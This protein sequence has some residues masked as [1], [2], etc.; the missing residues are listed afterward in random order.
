M[1]KIAYQKRQEK[2]FEVGTW[3][4][5]SC[6]HPVFHISRL[7]EFKGTLPKE[8]VDILEEPLPFVQSTSTITTQCDVEKDGTERLE[9][10]V[11][12][13]GA[14]CEDATW[15]DWKHLSKVF[16]NVQLKDKLIFKG[17][18]IDMD[19]KP[20][21]INK[22]PKEPSGPKLSAEGPRESK[23]TRRP[24]EWAKDYHM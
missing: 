13:T 2:A 16:P 23:R 11:E 21:P 8:L 22:H 14:N 19:G 4:W 15:E 9:V 20:N 12:W 7:K 18:G 3:V 1:K 24:L 17:G 10:L 5:A 6:V